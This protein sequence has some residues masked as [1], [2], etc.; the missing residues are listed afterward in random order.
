MRFATLW[1]KAFADFFVERNQADR[2]LL[3]DHQITKRGSQADGILKLCQF[4]PVSIAH[5][6]R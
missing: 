6:G 5:G 2:V 3:L 4:L 1:R